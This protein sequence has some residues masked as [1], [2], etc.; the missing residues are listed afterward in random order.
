MLDICLSD[1]IDVR[2][3]Y[4]N[5]RL[6][7][8]RNWG[9]LDDGYV[10]GL[11]KVGFDAFGFPRVCPDLH[12]ENDMN[13]GT[14]GGSDLRGLNMAGQGQLVTANRPP[15]LETSAIIRIGLKAISN[16]ITKQDK[17]ETK[18]WHFP[19]SVTQVI[20]VTKEIIRPSSEQQIVASP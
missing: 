15:I 14:R 18:L 1:D 10:F 6:R 8:R 17:L 5:H 13:C 11:E 20:Y 12:K 16:I 2:F 3:W 19:P 9:L 7:L 4:L